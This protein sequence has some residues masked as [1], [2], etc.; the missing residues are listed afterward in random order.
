[1]FNLLKKKLRINLLAHDGISSLYTGVGRIALDTLSVIANNNTL[2]R[3]VGSLNAI[4]GKYTDKC[5]GYS[6]NVRKTNIDLLRKMGGRLY[7]AINGSDG[8]ISY[9]DIRNWE[10][11]SASAATLLYVLTED[12]DFDVQINLCFDTPFAHVAELF[13][14]YDSEA[15][16]RNIFVWIP[17]S[18]VAIHKVDSAIK[19]SDSYFNDRMK[20]EQKAINLANEK[21]NIYVGYVGEFMKNHLIDVYHCNQ[22]RLIDFTN[23]LD[24]SAFRFKKTVSQNEIEE[25]LAKYN[26]STTSD[27][28]ISFGRLEQYKGFDYTIKIGGKLAGKNIK[29]VLMAQ[30]YSQDDPIVE[31]YKKMMSSDCL[32]GIFMPNYPFDL[33]HMLLRWHKTR[34]LL[35]PSRSEPFGLIPEEARLYQNPNLMIVAMNRGGL[36]EQIEDGEDGFLMNLSNIDE[37]AKKLTNLLDMDRETVEIIAKKGTQKALSKYNLANNF[38]KS[39]DIL[40]EK[41]TKK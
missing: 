40:M 39:I 6:K 19:G 5:L 38:E 29:T 28:M 13:Q 15:Q 18:T 14:Q 9:G 2:K 30:P 35:I 21:N 20:W 7:E 16:A 27:L 34:L 36:I 26:I 41:W 23:G 3:K 1:M 4:T 37:S 24:V 25:V 32:G 11:I 17:H 22:D 31:E 12:E 8:E 10:Y 33:P